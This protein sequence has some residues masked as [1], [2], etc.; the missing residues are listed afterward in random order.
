MGTN[1]LIEVHILGQSI[2]YDNI[3]RGL[4]KDGTIKKMIDDRDIVGITS[5]PAI[6]E[7]AINE[8]SDYDDD[9]KQL[10]NANKKLTSEELLDIL[11]KEDIGMAADLL[12]PVYDASKGK[13]GYVSIE[14][15]PTLAADTA[16]TIKEAKRL[17]SEI[18]K[19]NLMIK[20]PATNEGLEAVPKVLAEG[21]NVNITLM[22]SLQDYMDVANAYLDGLDL[23][24][25]QAGDLS[26]IASVAS[27]FISRID[28]DVDNELAVDSILRG[29]I[30]VANAK[31]TYSFYE[32]IF[33]SNRFKALEAK[34][35]R[36][37]RVLWASTGTKNPDY[38]DTKYLD[39]L[40]GS[41]TVNTVPANTLVAFKD[42][43]TA[44][45][46]LDKGLTEANSDL[47]MLKQEGISLDRITK[48][49]KV[50]GV[51][52]FTDSYQTLLK[53][54]DS[55]KHQLLQGMK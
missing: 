44:K 51:N 36:K 50:K 28:A 5:N 41:N 16:N 24:N 42:H 4:I 14:V 31:I 27:F 53:S 15:A 19:P 37:Q 48:Q 33:S 10:L 47:E 34:G 38:K 49:L 25:K 26:K 23:L 1:P 7:K 30:A 32:K 11:M 9:I 29:K 46:T 52:A 21:I 8:S 12:K 54:L 43:G 13:D 45:L 55:K 3:S 20:I 2:W 17:F 6:F 18:N 39:E 40:I 35:A 22:F